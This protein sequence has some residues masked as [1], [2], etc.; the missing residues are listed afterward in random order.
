MKKIKTFNCGPVV[1]NTKVELYVYN[2]KD[3]K[4]VS[5][6]FA[7]RDRICPHSS[8]KIVQGELLYLWCVSPSGKKQEPA[9]III[10]I[11]RKN[12]L[13]AVFRTLP[14]EIDHF[15]GTISEKF[16]ITPGSEQ[17]A[18]LCGFITEVFQQALL[19]E[20]GYEIKEEI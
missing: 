13:S 7:L 19:K 17:L 20:L 12:K 10:N 16:D 4:S 1:A 2:A 15:I 18:Y 11:D 9:R 14:H 3:P 6:L 8:R 5:K